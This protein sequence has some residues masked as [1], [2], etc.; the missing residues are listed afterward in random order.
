MKNKDKIFSALEK[1]GNLKRQKLRKANHDCVDQALLK[2]FLGVRSQSVPVSAALIKE[3]AVQYAEAL[4][5]VYFTGYDGWLRRWKERNSIV[6][7]TV[8]VESNSVSSEMP[9]P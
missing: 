9:N 2:W 8:S 5:I 4:G 6:F 1:G 3:K 7:K